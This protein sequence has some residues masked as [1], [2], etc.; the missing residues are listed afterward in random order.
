M[1]LQIWWKDT[2]FNFYQEQ[3]ILF[4]FVL[5][6]KPFPIAGNLRAWAFASITP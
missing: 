4:I 6:Q 5:V 3:E 1:D 2:L